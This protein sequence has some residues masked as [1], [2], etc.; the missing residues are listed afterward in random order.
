[1]IQFTMLHPS[2]RAVELLGF[3]PAFLSEHDPRPAKEQFD[4]A[5]AHGGGWHPMK[6]WILYT[7]DGAMEYPGDPIYKPLARA[8]LRDETIYV[9]EHAWVS[10]VQKDRSFE[11]ARMD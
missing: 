4:S 10:I 11:V 9:Y 1:M 3:I 6:G 7:T 8:Q 2:P 5:Y